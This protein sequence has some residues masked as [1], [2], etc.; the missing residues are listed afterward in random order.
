MRLLI[1]T[2]LLS[3]LAAAL[4]TLALSSLAA[5]QPPAFLTLSDADRDGAVSR[6]EL[7]SAMSAWLAGQ[8]RASLDQFTSGLAASIPESAFLALISPPQSRS[9]KPED[10]EKMIAALPARAPAKPTRPRKVLVICKCAGFV[11]S[12]IP[13]AAKTIEMLGEKTGA[14]STTVSYEADVITA[15]NLKNY[16]AVFLNNTTGHFLDD[17]DPAVTAARKKALLD[18]V[19][20]GK[21]LAG[22]H[23][24]SDSYHRST[25]G[26][27]ILSRIAASLFA[28]ADQNEDK[29]VDTTEIN[30][31]AAKWFDSL[32]TAKSGKVATQDFR[33]GFSRLLFSTRGPR[34]S[35]PP[36]PPA[37]RTGP[38]HQIGTWPDFNRMIGGFFKY[39][40]NDPQHIVY[41]IDDPDSPLTAMFREGFEVND[42]TYTFGIRSWSRENL[43]VLTSVDYAKMSDADK[44]KEDY[45]REDHDYGLSWIRREGKGRVF[46]SA[47]GHSERV[48]ALRPMLEHLLAGTQY[49]LGDL[50]VNDRPSVKPK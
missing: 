31:L 9:P 14:W 7:T 12:C 3:T 6:D 4:A 8:P 21:G 28:A 43:R 39:H 46:Y 16:D 5:W 1:R 11:H 49:A 50:K 22:V 29:A 45:P 42:E 13:L 18:F 17:V 24:A 23:A 44:L 20:S 19:R 10:V 15:Q 48:Y 38:D 34:R 26:A 25:E 36:A 2:L 32:D 35:G 47:H 33:A 41:K 27:E 40:W 30:A 37:A